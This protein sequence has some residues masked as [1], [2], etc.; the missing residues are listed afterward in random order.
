MTKPRTGIPGHSGLGKVVNESAWGVATAQ[1]RY[2]KSDY[3]F[4]RATPQPD[5]KNKPQRLGSPNNLQDLPRYDNIHRDD[6]IRGKGESAEGKPNF[7]AGY[8]GKK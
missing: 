6:W 3:P 4:G 8:K 1:E 7:H 2:G 5:V